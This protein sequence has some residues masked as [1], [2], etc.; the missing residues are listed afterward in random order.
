MLEQFGIEPERY[1]FEFIAGS[2]GDKF[3]R[4][5]RDMVKEVR[6]IGPLTLTADTLKQLDE[7]EPAKATG[8]D[9]SD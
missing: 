2:E 5:A 9:T 4:V 3:A 7:L 8:G 6:E 1:R